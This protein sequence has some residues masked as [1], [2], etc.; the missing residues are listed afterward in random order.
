VTPFAAFAVAAAYTLSAR[1]AVLT[2]LCIWLANQV[3]GFGILGYPWTVDTV[4]WGLAIGA[5]ALL[6]YAFAG[7]TM[8]WLA[9]RNLVIA[10]GAALVMAFG[11]YEAGLFLVTFALGGEEAFTPAI[12]G[13]LGL[14]DLAWTVALVGIWQILR[15][16]GPPQRVRPGDAPASPADGAV[17]AAFFSSFG[18]T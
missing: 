8:A 1:A 6:A 14:I 2:F 15:R 16:A 3:I 4:L 13:R 17:H 11:A 12:V 9:R 7:L 18:R 5:A 10:L